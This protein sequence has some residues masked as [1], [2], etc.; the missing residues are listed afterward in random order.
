MLAANF[1][2]PAPVA[3]LRVPRGDLAKLAGGAI[4]NAKL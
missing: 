3:G 2:N 4:G 1:L